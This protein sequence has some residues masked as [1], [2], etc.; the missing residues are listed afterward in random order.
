MQIVANSLSFSPSLVAVL[1]PCNHHLLKF[2]YY[3]M[4]TP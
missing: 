1:S 2:S 3:A 4:T